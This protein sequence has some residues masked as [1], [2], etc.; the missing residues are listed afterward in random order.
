ML[1]A[2]FTA[3]ALLSMSALLRSLGLTVGL[4]ALAL[5]AC[6]AAHVRVLPEE[7]EAGAYTVLDVNVPNESADLATTK[8]VV[9][10][11]PGFGYALYQPVAGWSGSVRVTKPTKSIIDGRSTPA[12]VAR[13]TWV[14]RRPDA[15]IQPQQFKDFPIAVQIPSQVGKRLTFR[16]LQT[17]ED[18]DVVRWTGSPSSRSPAPQVLLTAA[19]EDQVAAATDAAAVDEDSGGGSDGLAIAALIAGLLGLLAGVAALARS[20]QAPKEAPST[21]EAASRTTTRA[22]PRHRRGG[23][24]Q[25]WGRR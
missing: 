3:I 13:V 9:E 21:A 6:V 5:P 16:A 7:V 18:G 17:Y 1:A 24:R 25:G 20:L 10:F 22:Y 2:G 15:E 4:L 11:P 12:R 23:R 14:A 19:G 8:V